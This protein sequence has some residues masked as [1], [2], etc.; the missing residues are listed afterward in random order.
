M[1]GEQSPLRDILNAAIDDFNPTQVLI[2]CDDETEAVDLAENPVALGSDRAGNFQ[3]DDSVDDHPISYATFTNRLVPLLRVTNKDGAHVFSDHD[4]KAEYKRRKPG[5]TN[6]NLLP[7]ETYP[8][9]SRSQALNNARHLAGQESLD[10]LQNGLTLLTFPPSQQVFT[11][12]REPHAVSITYDVSVDED[13][14]ML[15]I[16]EVKRS[17]DHDAQPPVANQYTGELNP[18]DDL[19]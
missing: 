18:P 8:V 17:L 12:Q 9:L 5:Y 19:A 15:G 7:G 6:E 1:I 4:I 16:R 3:I 10:R 13:T 14:Y 2:S 11:T